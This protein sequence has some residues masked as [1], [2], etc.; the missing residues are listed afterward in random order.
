[1]PSLA[2][3][4]FGAAPAPKAATTVPFVRPPLSPDE[5]AALDEAVTALDAE[6]RPRGWHVWRSTDPAGSVYATA[7]AVTEHAETAGQMRD[8]LAGRVAEA[9]ADRDVLL[10]RWP[11]PGEAAAGS[12]AGDRELRGSR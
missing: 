9:T 3:R 10:S 6:F 8:L 11:D 7:R 1:M 5:M 2:A 12:L 4:F